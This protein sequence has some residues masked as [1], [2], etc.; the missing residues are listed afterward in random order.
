MNFYKKLS[1]WLAGKYENVNFRE[2]IDIQNYNN[3]DG[4]YTDTDKYDTCISQL[5]F[6]LWNNKSWRQ[7]AS[8]EL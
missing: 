5:F 8:S 6:L 3:N 4:I 7:C 1:Q 2:N